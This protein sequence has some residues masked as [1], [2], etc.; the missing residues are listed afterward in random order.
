VRWF[1][2]PLQAVPINGI[3]TSSGLG[4][5]QPA[6]PESLRDFAVADDVIAPRP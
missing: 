1:N 5:V 6:G 4:D 2:K 3:R